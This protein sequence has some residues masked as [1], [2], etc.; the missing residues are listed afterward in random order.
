M[1]RDP[2]W[3]DMFTQH[4]W[5]RY[6]AEDLV[7]FAAQRLGARQ[8]RSDTRVLEVGL[9]PAPTSGSL[10]VKAMCSQRARGQ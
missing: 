8:P 4:A 1:A 10:P 6:P 5:G 7:R 2:L 9:A 3:E